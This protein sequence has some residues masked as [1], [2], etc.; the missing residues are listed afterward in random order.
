GK[1]EIKTLY[2]PT[3]RRVQQECLQEMSNRRSVFRESEIE[4]K[5]SDCNIT[6]AHCASAHIPFQSDP[7]SLRFQSKKSCGP[8]AACAVD[9][10]G[11]NLDAPTSVAR[12]SLKFLG[13][14]IRQK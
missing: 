8:A 13:L 14:P 10:C 7:V 3:L 9:R 12:R 11:S 2:A 6:F 5:L 4:F 1:G